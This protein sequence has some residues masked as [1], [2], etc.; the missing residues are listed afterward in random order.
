LSPDEVAGWLDRARWRA[1]PGVEP[2]LLRARLTAA[3]A[4]LAA[5]PPPTKAGRRKALYAL[6]LTG[7]APDHLLKVESCAARPLG[8]RLGR[9][10]AALELARASACAA[11]GVP[12][13][14]PLAAGAVRRCG[15]LEAVLLLVPVVPGA[16]DLARRWDG[17][18]APRALRRAAGPALGAL[19]R[20]LHEAGV[21]QDDLAPNNFLWRDA[22]E[23]RLL[24]IDFERVRIVRRVSRA[25]RALALARLDRHL[26]G[27]STSDRLRVARA[28]GQ[29]DGRTWWRAVAAAHGPLARR[30][31][32]HLLRTGTRASRRFAPVAE[33]GVSGWARRGAP[34]EEALAAL[35]SA[36]HA[37]PRL[38]VTPL[39]ALDAEARARAWAAALVLAQRGAAPAPVA[40]LAREDGC[41]LAAERGAGARPLASAAPR[42]AR[43]S[44]VGLLDRLLA[45]GFEP[46]ALARE[47]IVLTPLPGGGARAE[48]LDPRGL[49]PGRVSAPP[50]GGARGWA[51]RLLE[52]PGPVRGY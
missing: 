32:A 37:P 29:G 18:R 13:P 3:R 30:D 1:G 19:V 5:G 46:G 34:L 14:L 36:G 45:F 16:A 20:T 2:A 50:A 40:L 9:G 35:G 17:G 39:G 38:W 4:A 47:A 15:L 6:A 52:D 31:F 10:A 27:A 23:P 22:P 25:R 49:R 33:P 11:L 48:L 42:D 44:L 21:D 7:P 8:R 43:A 51:A 28:Y 24:A 41:F 12:T 26:A